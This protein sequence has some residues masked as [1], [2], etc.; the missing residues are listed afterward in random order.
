[1]ETIQE[2]RDGLDA[3]YQEFKA[4]FRE[5]EK[6]VKSKLSLAGM[7][8]AG[9]L[10][11]GSMTLALGL[12]SLGFAASA[13]GDEAKKQTKHTQPLSIFLDLERHAS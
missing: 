11:S 2:F 9:A 7:T 1:L 8:G 13:W 6:A 10:V 4:E 12:A 5:I 3:Q